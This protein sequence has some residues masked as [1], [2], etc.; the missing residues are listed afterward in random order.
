MRRAC[1]EEKRR[2]WLLTPD[3]VSSV[4]LF[5]LVGAVSFLRP[6]GLGQGQEAGGLKR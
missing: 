2:I 6:R 3:D 1:D 5:G 4:V